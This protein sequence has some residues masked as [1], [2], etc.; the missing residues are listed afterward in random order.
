[1][2]NV[3]AEFDEVEI[4]RRSETALKRALS[5]PRK[6]QSEMRLGRRSDGATPMSKRVRS[7]NQKPTFIENVVNADSVDDLKLALAQWPRF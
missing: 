5:M 6:K 1:M 4:V 7:L 3:D 2:A